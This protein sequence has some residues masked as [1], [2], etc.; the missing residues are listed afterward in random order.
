MHL[1]ILE[2]PWT[3]AQFI[4]NI[5][6]GT[7]AYLV[8]FHRNIRASKKGTQKARC[9]WEVNIEGEPSKKRSK[10]GKYFLLDN[11]PIWQSW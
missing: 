2:I 7:G 1:Y 8:R 9:E 10:F 3:S 6:R 5:N 4:Q 11:L